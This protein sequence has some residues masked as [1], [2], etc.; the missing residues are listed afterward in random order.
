VN[1]QLPFPISPQDALTQIVRPALAMLPARMSSP[2]AAVQ[3]LAQALQES[4][5]KHRRQ[6][7]GPARGL[8][9]FET[10]G[11]A[12]VLRH[13][14][15]KVHA[16]SVCVSRGV[17]PVTSEVYA[18][19]EHDDIL[20]AA[21]ARL[22]LWTDPRPLPKLGDTDEAWALYTRTWRPGKPHRHTWDKLYH[23][24]HRAVIGVHP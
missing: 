21:F 19:L 17:E 4:R 10:G 22:L 7:R 6:I 2:Q 13:S 20:A 24:A 12:G 18:R 23:D 15:S 14:A 9:Q 5:L 1:A 3:M 11:I 8:W 16:R